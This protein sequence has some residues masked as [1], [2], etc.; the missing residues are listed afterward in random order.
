V[1]DPLRA[2]GRADDTRIATLGGQGRRGWLAWKPRNIA[3]G[4]SFSASRNE[5]G[6]LSMKRLATCWIAVFGVLAVLVGGSAAT[7]APTSAPLQPT[8]TSVTSL[9]CPSP[10]VCVGID[11]GG[12][13][14]LVTSRSPR[15]GSAAW[16]SQTIGQGGRLEGAGLRLGALVLGG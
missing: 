11:N 7:A 2:T 8:L 9:Q 1:I 4:F 10:S 3:R 5:F 6:R 16:V 15:L 14:D 13:G 12:T